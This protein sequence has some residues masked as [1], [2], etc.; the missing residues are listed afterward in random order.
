MRDLQSVCCSDCNLKNHEKTLV[1]HGIRYRRAP[2]RLHSYQMLHP[3]QRW[4]SL[5]QGSRRCLD[6]NWDDAPCFWCAVVCTLWNNFLFHSNRFN[7]AIKNFYFIF[8]KYIF[9]A[10]HLTLMRGKVISGPYMRHFQP[11][12][13]ASIAASVCLFAETASFQPGQTRLTALAGHLDFEFFQFP[14]WVFQF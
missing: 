9:T 12:C 14:I 13:L 3:Q 1:S 4:K 2:F 7:M 6:F 11:V 5:N 10:L 8:F